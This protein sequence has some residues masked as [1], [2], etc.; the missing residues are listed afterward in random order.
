MK[1]RTVGE[2]IQEA[3]ERG[4]LPVDTKHCLAEAENLIIEILHDMAEA[5]RGGIE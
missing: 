5:D 2:R 1:I 3:L 4:H